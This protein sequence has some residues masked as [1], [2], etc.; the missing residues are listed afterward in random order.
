MV[1]LRDAI[2][3]SE[4]RADDA[5]LANLQ[6]EVAR[7]RV[8][9]VESL[10]EFAT[11]KCEEYAERHADFKLVNFHYERLV[12]DQQEDL[13]AEERSAIRGELEMDDDELHMMCDLSEQSSDS[14]ADVLDVDDEQHVDMMVEEARREADRRAASQQMEVTEEPDL[15]DWN[16]E[17]DSNMADTNRH[18]SQWVRNTTPAIPHRQPDWLNKASMSNQTALTAVPEPPA[19]KT[20]QRKKYTQKD[21]LFDICDPSF[22][23][24]LQK[25]EK[26]QDFAEQLIEKIKEFDTD[27]RPLDWDYV[28]K[29][30][31][32]LAKQFIK[33]DPEKG[34]LYFLKW[35]KRLEDKYCTMDFFIGII[36]D[37][38]LVKNSKGYYELLRIKKMWKKTPHL[39]KILGISKTIN[40]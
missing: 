16:N 8:R 2:R 13:V 11:F 22:P 5:I 25:I 28:V 12:R 31:S 23:P 30:S 33:A 10:E 6:C 32:T 34:E 35:Q 18:V 29:K 36:Q 27:E 20:S 3:K 38:F 4:S 40:K 15:P 39:E 24:I 9:G 21:N 37:L 26:I 1:K 17:T 19:K 14:A 7:D